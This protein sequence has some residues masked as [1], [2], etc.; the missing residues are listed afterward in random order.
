MYVDDVQIT[1]A[2]PPTD[3]PALVGADQLHAAGIT[4]DGVTVAVL[5]T[6]FWSNPALVRD[7]S[8]QP[9][10]PGYYDAFSG[11]ALDWPAEPPEVN[12]DENGHGSHVAS[13]VLS[14]LPASDGTYN[15][16]APDA[17]L[18]PVRAFDWE[19]KGTYADIIEAI[20]YVIKSKDTYNTRVLNL[21]FSA[22]PQSYYWDDPLNQA[23]MRAWQAG[24][25]V[26]AAGATGD[27]MP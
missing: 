1:Y 26:I 16:V 18:L 17:N 14:S 22:E 3:Y 21:S 27:P 13:I 10:V 11:L 12:W 8:G 24:I 5:D 6:G 23:V 4:G 15:G 2:Y 9:R 7:T 25:V 19:G 20:D